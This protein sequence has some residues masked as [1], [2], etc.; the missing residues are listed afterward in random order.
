[1]RLAA[2]AQK[3]IVIEKNK[4]LNSD[5]ILRWFTKVLDM[6]K[7]FW[8]LLKYLAAHIPQNKFPPQNNPPTNKK[9]LSTKKS[10]VASKHRESCQSFLELP[11]DLPAGGG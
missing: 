1:M 7:W 5:V 4:S 9:S 6:K 2:N 10:I 11:L 8:K 3:Q